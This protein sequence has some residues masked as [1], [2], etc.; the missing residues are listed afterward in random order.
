MKILILGATGY[1]GYHITKHF[2]GKSYQV[3]CI[4][5]NCSSEKMVA[6][7]Q[8]MG[9]EIFYK[10]NGIRAMLRQNEFDWIVNATCVY[11]QNEDGYID[12]L[13]ANLIYPL[14]VLNYASFLK[15]AKFITIGTG[16]PKNFNMYSYTKYEL[17]DFGKKFCEEGDMLFCEVRAELFYG[18][19]EPPGRFM[20]MCINK[21][22]AE[23]ELALTDGKQK[24]DII[25]IEDLIHA[26]DCI[27]A[28][29]AQTPSGYYVYETGIGEAVS[30]RDIVCYMAEKSGSNAKLS[31]GAVP[32]RKNEP[33]C[34]ADITELKNIG[35]RPQYSWKS[36]IDKLIKEHMKV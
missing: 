13:N 22:I 31:F 29:L 30:I 27:M 19:E 2:I 32:A 33:D 15:N 17:T 26:V 28:A 5:R 16:L 4:V 24:R 36:G 12:M 7:L 14:E 34:V 10:E 3:T 18:Q 35:F 9:A 21:L 25:R 6:A 20:Q 1:L 23:E 11:N 8:E